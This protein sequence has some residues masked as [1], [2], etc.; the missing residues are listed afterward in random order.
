[1]HFAVREAAKAPSPHKSGFGSGMELGHPAKGD[2]QSAAASHHA[3]VH[4][5][6]AE[7]VLPAPRSRKESEGGTQV[8][9][10]GPVDETQTEA[11]A[12]AVPYDAPPRP[13]R[14]CA[15]APPPAFPDG[16]D[17]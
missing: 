11:V 12:V 7:K 13:A 14:R 15:V 10:A 2:P 4:A 16:L 1:M 5:V 9:M 3:S 17:G 8:G 6:P